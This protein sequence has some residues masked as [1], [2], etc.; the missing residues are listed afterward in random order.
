MAMFLLL[1]QQI[2]MIAGLALIGQFVV[3]IFAWGKRETN[4][5]YRFFR[6]V[7]SPAV[8]L[9]RYITPKFVPDQHV[10]FAAFSLL[11]VLFLWLGLE[12]RDVCND[13]LSAAGCERWR[14]AREAQ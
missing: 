6:I 13:N 1:L 12:H 3:G 11:L 5:I 9:V 7:G 4:P 10:P 14:E 2:V 8:K